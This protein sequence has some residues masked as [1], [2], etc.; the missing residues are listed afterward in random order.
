MISQNFEIQNEQRKAEKQ[1]KVN[2]VVSCFIG[3]ISITTI[4]F[5]IFII[6]YGF[7]HLQAK[8]EGDREHAGYSDQLPGTARGPD[9]D[10]DRE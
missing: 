5:S 7:H 8:F 10:G 3:F 2:R 6:I 9:A 4:I 1:K